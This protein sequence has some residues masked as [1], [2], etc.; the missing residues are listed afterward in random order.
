MVLVLMEVNVGDGWVGGGVVD[1]VVLD[2]FC[3]LSCGLI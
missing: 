2:G 1:G 3:E